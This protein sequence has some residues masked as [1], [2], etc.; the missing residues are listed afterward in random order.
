TDD[1]HI[2]G[3]TYSN[4]YLGTNFGKGS[5]PKRIYV[6]KVPDGFKETDVLCFEYEEQVPEGFE[7]D[8]KVMLEKTIKAPIER[9]LEAM[10]WSWSE[11]RSSQKQTVLG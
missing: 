7:P 8:W 2:R 11:I 1:A 3:A 4:K 6:G 10:G 5:K 9:V